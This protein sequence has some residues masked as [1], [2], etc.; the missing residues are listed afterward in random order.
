MDPIYKSRRLLRLMSKE[1]PPIF[2]GRGNRRCQI[3]T[4]NTRVSEGAPLEGFRRPSG[5]GGGVSCN[6]KYEADGVSLRGG[7]GLYCATSC[8]R[9]QL[10]I[11]RYHASNLYLAYPQSRCLT[12]RKSVY[13]KSSYN[14]PSGRDN[15]TADR[16]RINPA[17][18]ANASF[19]RFKSA[20]E[21]LLEH[22]GKCM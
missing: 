20:L 16:Y 6:P 8:K 7:V 2:Q 22:M 10:C 12:R 11:T 13:T 9:E 5:K 17:F 3:P 19:F 4:G 14:K 15:V 1:T 18:S 21:C